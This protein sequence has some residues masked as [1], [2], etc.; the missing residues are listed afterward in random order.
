MDISL[1][2]HNNVTCYILEDNLVQ[3]IMLTGDLVQV[4]R[5]IPTV[6]WSLTA[7]VW[8]P[9]WVMAFP[10]GQYLMKPS[11]RLPSPR[12]PGRSSLRR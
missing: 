2:L 1:G 7:V 4:A 5:F 12:C 9:F 11:E 3:L 10:S 8:K 6:H